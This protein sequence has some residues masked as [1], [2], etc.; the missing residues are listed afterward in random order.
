MFEPAPFHPARHPHRVQPKSRVRRAIEAHAKREREAEE[1]YKRQLRAEKAKQEQAEIKRKLESHDAE[2]GYLSTARYGA[3]E[4]RRDVDG[5]EEKDGDRGWKKA[6]MG[7]ENGSDGKVVCC[8]S[9]FSMLVV[10]SMIWM[11][12]I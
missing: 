9:L 3:W 7:L 4:V 12:W 6:F 11:K 8:C 1:A 5:G 10:V 2:D